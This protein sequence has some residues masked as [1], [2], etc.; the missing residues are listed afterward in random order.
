VNKPLIAR[1]PPS[2]DM[3]SWTQVF[4]DKQYEPVVDLIKNK[5]SPLTI[6]DCG[7][8][9]GYA[10]AYFKENLPNSIILALEL[11]TDNFNILKHNFSGLAWNSGVWSKDLATLEVCKDYRD[12]KEWS[13]YAKESSIGAISSHTIES[14]RKHMIWDKIDIL[15]I[16]IE[17]GESE[18]FKD[19]SFLE[20]V[21][22]I[23]IEIHDEFKCRAQI[24]SSL[25]KYKFRFENYGEL[26][27]G[28]KE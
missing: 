6:L 27:V 24:L 18:V 21:E 7:A 19:D 8:N 17:G 28:Y 1:V 16:D 26:T 15:K 20:H 12:R 23:A 22:I 9:V 25:M 5:L 4:R 3:L 13:Y 2:S 11:D 14:I 10:S